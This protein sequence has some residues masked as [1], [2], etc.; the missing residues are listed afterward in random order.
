[1]ILNGV[2][3]THIHKQKHESKNIYTN[4]NDLVEVV[5]LSICLIVASLLYAIFLSVICQV[6][7][8]NTDLCLPAYMYF[9]G[10]FRQSF[11]D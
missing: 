8:C 4:R 2:R 5:C 3:S 7:V 11:N 9:S 10:V 6:S 1:M